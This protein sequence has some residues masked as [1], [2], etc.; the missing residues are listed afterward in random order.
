MIYFVAQGRLG[1]VMLEY[2]AA[3]CLGRGEPTAIILEQDSLAVIKKYPQFFGGVRIANEFPKDVP[4]WRQTEFGFGFSKIPN[5]DDLVIQGTFL[6]EK[7]FDR[8]TILDKF[9]PSRE[10]ADNLKKR[11]GNWLTRPH[12]TSIHVRRGDYLRQQFLFP[13][14]GKN[15]YRAAISKLPECQDFI[16]CSDDI[17]WCKRFFTKRFKGRRF[18]FAEG[19]SPLEDVYLQSLCEN[20]IISNG[21]FAWWAAWLNRHEGKRVLAPSR[22]FGCSVAHKHYTG[23]IYFKGVE[24]VENRYDFFDYFYA[25]YCSAR[26]RA[27]AYLL[28]LRTFV[29]RMV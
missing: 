18:M 8:T 2:A 11:F 20:N 29:K 12:V 7:Y 25:R 10:M 16:V 4:V 24:I 6:S 15:Y 1:N 13:F 19:N 3:K 14:A 21:T 23:D 28:K 9:S 5:Y 27:A 17:P 22:W 26:F